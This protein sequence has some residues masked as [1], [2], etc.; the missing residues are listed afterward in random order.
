MASI[1]KRPDGR[2]RVRWRDPEGRER[3][4]HFARKVDAERWR[5]TVT[6][7]MVRGA[8]VDP[9]AGR[10]TFRDFAEQWRTAQPARPNTAA[11]HQSTLERHVYPAIGGLALAAVRPSQVQAMVS[12]WS[13]AAG[14]VRTV[15]STVRAVF[16][17]AVRD[18]AIGLDP[19]KG[20]KLP[21]VERKRITPLTVEQVEA[22]ADAV[23]A[24]YRALV[25]LAAGT[26][27]RQG[28][29]F[30]VQLG[31]VDW[32]RRSLAVQRQVQPGPVVGPLKNRAAYRV[33]PLGDVV[34]AELAEHLRQWPAGSPQSF[35]FRYGDGPCTRNTFNASVWRPAVKRAGLAGVGMHD[36]RHAYASL[37][38][39]AGQSVKVVSDRLGHSNAAMTLNVYS[40]LFP[41]DE[42]R[43]R[44]AV[45]DAFRRKIIP[46][47]DRTRTAEGS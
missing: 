18:R 2:Y 47:A 32:L 11:R 33:I 9:Q 27:L 21:A 43:T 23:P 26:G 28:E 40:H 4:K 20:V 6:A 34:L 25:V 31:D 7:D 41:A 30:G 14:S 8:Y 16:S 13:L 15:F 44:Q 22:I 1:Q 3:A 10:V 38:I 19:C 42:D 45:D 24:E 37:L 35:V 5:A 12:G 39:A 36:L 29:A 17:A 46:G